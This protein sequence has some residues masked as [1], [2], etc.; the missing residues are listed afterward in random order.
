MAGVGNPARSR[1]T[2]NCIHADTNLKTRVNKGLLIITGAR[3]LRLRGNG[4]GV[5]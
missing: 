2:K 4:Q 5:D 3:D 1:D